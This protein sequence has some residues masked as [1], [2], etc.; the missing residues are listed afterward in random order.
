MPEILDSLHSTLMK[1]G[2]NSGQAYAIA[3]GRLQ[4]YGI[5]KKGT[6]VLT[7]KGKVREKMGKSK[8]RKDRK[9]NGGK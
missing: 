7:E 1:K 5:L 2:Y 6:V 9:K 8:R 4:E 3:V